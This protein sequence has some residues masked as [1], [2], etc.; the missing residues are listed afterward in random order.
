MG[1]DKSWKLERNIG[2]EDKQLTTPEHDKLCMWIYTHSAEVLCQ[3]YRIYEKMK[4]PGVVEKGPALTCD[5]LVWEEPIMNGKFVVGIPDFSYSL[6]I[7][8]KVPEENGKTCE[9][10]DRGYIEVK[11]KIYSLGEV[12]RQVKLYKQYGHQ[13]IILVTSTPDYKDIFEE[14]KIGYVVHALD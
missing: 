12:M 6:T 2:T 10:S 14:Q 3:D 1:K 13:H 4:E 11:P 8:T 5:T 9:I 7:H